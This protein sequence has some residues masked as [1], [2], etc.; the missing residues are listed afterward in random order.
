MRWAIGAIGFMLTASCSQ[1]PYPPSASPNNAVETAA[2]GC[3]R[4]EPVNQVVGVR[5]EADLR[6]EPSQ[7]GERIVNQRATEA[8]GGRT[9][10]QLIDES[11]TVRVHC[12]EGDWSHVQ[13]VEPAWLTEHRGWVPTSVLRQIERSADGARVYVESDFYWEDNTRPYRSQ[14]IRAVNRIHREQP[15][16]ERID[17]GTV[18]KSPQRGSPGRPVFFVSCGE[19]AGVFN[20]WFRPDGSIVQSGRRG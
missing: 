11:T 9:Q 1:N 5:R 15:G 7:Q 18:A 8:F 12:R 16:C 13:I 6:R 20:V 14:I 17:P 3:G 4:G 19:G 10:Y 2:V